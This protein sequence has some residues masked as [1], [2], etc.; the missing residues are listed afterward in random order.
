[1]D[2]ASIKWKTGAPETDALV[3]E[4]EHFDARGMRHLYGRADYFGR[5]NSF[6]MDIWATADKCLLMRFWSR[7]KEIDW[8]SYE[9]KGINLAEVPKRSKSIGLSE[10]WIPAVVRQVYEQWIDEEF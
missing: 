1:M 6:K 2:N 7:C 9:I 10:S 5:R 4:I 8:R 3:L